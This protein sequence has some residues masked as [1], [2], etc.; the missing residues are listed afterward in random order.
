M[1]VPAQFMV[2]GKRAVRTLT[3][4]H[5]LVLLF[6]VHAVIVVTARIAQQHLSLEAILHFHHLRLAGVDN[7]VNPARCS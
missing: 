2:T 5:G 6:R 4:L 3:Q 1:A 7:K